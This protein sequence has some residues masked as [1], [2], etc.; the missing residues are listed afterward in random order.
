M[1]RE[2]VLRFGELRPA[3]PRRIA[4]PCIVFTFAQPGVHKIILVYTF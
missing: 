1:Q 2:C 3:P 4:L